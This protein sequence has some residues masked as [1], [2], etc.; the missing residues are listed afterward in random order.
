MS[1]LAF[2]YK[3]LG[4]IKVEWQAATKE[5][6]VV[7]VQMAVLRGQME[8]KQRASLAVGHCSSPSLNCTE[9]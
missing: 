7:E 1:R 2:A 5:A 6:R 4:F 9:L 3:F 8:E